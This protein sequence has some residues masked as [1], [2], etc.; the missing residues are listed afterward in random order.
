MCVNNDCECINENDGGGWFINILNYKV[1]HDIIYEPNKIERNI[2]FL[3]YELSFQSNIKSRHTAIILDKND[4]IKCVFLNKKIVGQK[5]SEHA[6]SGV[7]KKFKEE[8][9]D[10]LS[11][12]YKLLVVKGTVYGKANS[13]PCYECFKS[14]KKSGIKEVIYSYDKNYYKKMYVDKNTIV[15]FN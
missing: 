8:F 5:K 7:I 15:T 13:R 10:D 11:D 9:D 3:A 4:N 2:F 12:G 6:E 14:I 1:P